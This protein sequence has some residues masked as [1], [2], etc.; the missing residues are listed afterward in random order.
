MTK[1]TAIHPG[2]ILSRTFMRPLRM[3]AVTLHFASGLPTF[4]IKELIAGRQ[5]IDR[6]TALVLGESLGTGPEFW[7][8]VQQEFENE[9]REHQMA[10]DVRNTGIS[11]LLFGYRKT[12]DANVFTPALSCEFCGTQSISTR[13]CE[14]VPLPLSIC[15]A[16]AVAF[17][18]DGCNAAK[19]GVQ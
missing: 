8:E 4:Q 15:D 17:A 18:C 12:S 9:Q 13:Q 2:Y 6:R 19:G 1:L 3:D 16:C 7:L 5:D 10:G 14:R 11:A